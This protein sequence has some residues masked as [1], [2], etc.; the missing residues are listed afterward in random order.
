VPY[1]SI[2][3][4]TYNRA[5]LLKET[6]ASVLSQTLADFELIIVDDGSIDNTQEEVMLNFQDSR[7][8]YIYQENAERGAAR[9][10]GIKVAKGAYIVFM[11]SDDIMLPNHLTILIEG[12]KKH[13]NAKLFAHNYEFFDANGIITNSQLKIAPGIYG[14][15]VLLEGNPFA[16]NF[17]IQNNL[18]SLKLFEQD[19]KYAI[20]EDWMFL[21][22][23][24]VDKKMVVLDEVTVQ[25]R[26]HDNRSMRSK[27]ELLCTKRIAATHWIID[28]KILTND[29]INKLWIGSYRFS[30]IH[31]YIDGNS[32][33]A[34]G[35][36]LSLIRRSGITINNIQ[37]ML[38]IIIRKKNIEFL[39][40]C[41]RKIF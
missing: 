30:A 11:D 12:I 25:M 16:V 37:L 10:Q 35:Y 1:F 29:E 41:Y 9:N 2:I 6:I 31:H 40:K 38:K 19:R 15:S 22:E 33:K 7:I 14:V 5:N 17:S 36:L 23:N 4:S 13:S 21:V 34:F 3:I 28:K 8:I 20:M 32:M 27:A 39:K 26:D 24:L 18:A